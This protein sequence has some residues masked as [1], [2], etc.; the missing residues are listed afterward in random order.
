MNEPFDPKSYWENRLSAEFSLRGV[1]HISFNEF[2]NRWMYRKKRYVLWS[3]FRGVSLRGR[4]VLDIGCGTGFFVQWYIKRG[5]AVYGID[6]AEV[7]VANLSKRFKEAE[8]SVADI[9]S[10]DYVPPMKFDI[11]NMWD[12]IYHQVEDAAFVQTFKNI[13]QA[14]KQDTP[15]LCTDQFGGSSDI[16]VASHVKFRCLQTYKDV[17]PNLGFK[18]VKIVPLYGVLNKRY[19]KLGA[20]NNH[21][22]PLFFLM[23]LGMRSISRD[24]LSVSV[25][26]FSGTGNGI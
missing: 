9:S 13:A 20:Y 19:E 10:R 23:D 21:L 26:Q 4:S 18:L 8:F 11:V 7:S 12:V 15:V 3:L 24:N 6:I 2:Y 17:L 1:G 14:C 5:A 25:W 22:A 16:Q